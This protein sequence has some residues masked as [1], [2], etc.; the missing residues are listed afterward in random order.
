MMQTPP[1][2]LSLL[3]VVTEFL[4]HLMGLRDRGY[5]AVLIS[6]PL[7][8]MRRWVLHSQLSLLPALKNL[9]W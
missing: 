6:L 1:H 8:T 5:A 7:E 9:R 4:R 3:F 2:F